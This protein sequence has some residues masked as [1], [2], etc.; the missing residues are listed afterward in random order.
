[1]DNNPLRQYFRRPAVYIKL[2]SGGVGYSPD[3]LIMP[4]SGELPVYPMTAIDEIT[5]RTPDA[6]FNGTAITELIK[7]CIPNIK[8][9]WVV[10][11]NDMDAI[12][13]GIKAA[14]GNEILNVD[15]VC[16]SCEEVNSYSANLVSILSTLKSGDYASEFEVKDFY[17]KFRPLTFKE[18]NEAGMKQFELQ[19]IIS[20]LTSVE[21]AEQRDKVG[22][23]IVERV[24]LLTMEL[25]AAS[26]EYVKT[27]NVVV[28]D[29]EFILEFLKNCDR[30]IYNAVRDRNAELKSATELKPLQVTCPSCSHE[31]EQPFTLNPADFFE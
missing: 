24:T 15:S 5:V 10:T 7:S 18:L 19:K 21:D 25:S 20:S 31:Y 13:V 8:N 29:Q 23:D 9:P 30:N 6:L 16:P 4:E 3:D 2:P 28:K 26:I 1:M 14:S 22:Y 12:L 11:S 27:D 17:I